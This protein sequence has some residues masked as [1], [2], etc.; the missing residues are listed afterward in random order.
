M[1]TGHGM[2]SLIPPKRNDAEI[3]KEEHAQNVPKPITKNVFLEHTRIQEKETVERVAER[4][5][6]QKQKLDI[7]PESVFQIEIEKI[8]SNPYQPRK[9]FNKE[10]LEELAQSISEF[11]VIQPITVSKIVKEKP[12]GADVEY[13]LIAGER[14]LMASKIAGLERIPAII[15][16]VDTGKIRLEMAL[17]ENIQRSDLNALD[18]GKAYARL[19]DEFGLTQREIAVRMGKSR[20]VI[21]NTLRL[22]NLPSHIQ[23]ALAEGKITE[24]QAR[25]LLSFENITEQQKAFE[26]LLER[27]TLPRASRE[28]G[29]RGHSS[30]QNPEELHLERQLEE[31]LGAPV[32]II[33]NK[34][35]GRIV[36]E[37]YSRDEWQSIIDSLLRDEMN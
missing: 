5:Y 1:T 4:E 7:K 6:G 24:S 35:K 17:I 16:K 11:G 26:Q 15:K 18:A 3:K 21:A 25:G 37:F 22:L 8:K 36:I 29:P 28:K 19:Q 32:K 31:K 2:Q 14:R 30:N 23:T 34:D 33:K 20:E 12:G 10:D 9:T 27:K 13:Q